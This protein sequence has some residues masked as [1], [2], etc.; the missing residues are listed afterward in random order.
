MSGRS[1]ALVGSILC[2]LVP[3][4]LGS[5]IFA[6]WYFTRWSWLELAG[7]WLLPFG[8]LGVVFGG[9]LLWGHWREERKRVDRMGLRLRVVLVG[10]L[11]LGNFAV[12]LFYTVAAMQI[13][14]RYTVQV[15]NESGEVIESFV[16]TGPGVEIELGALKP[17]EK[18][19]E[20][21]RFKPDGRL[22]F[23]FRQGKMETNGTLEGYVT[24]NLG[25]ET[26]IRVRQGGELEILR[27]G[28]HG[29]D[30]RAA[31]FDLQNVP[32]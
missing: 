25:G 8:S 4:F 23:S 13:A 31:G 26:R 12:A 32:E 22:E 19:R 3:L 16:L 9:F 28:G 5:L 21:L 18:A 1:R 14:T 15:E 27:K 10:V 7:I 2:G 20:Y 29:R 11:L 17:G 24:G 6:A 30:F